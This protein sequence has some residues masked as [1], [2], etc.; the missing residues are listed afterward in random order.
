[1]G[2]FTLWIDTEKVEL[3]VV[4]LYQAQCVY[5]KHGAGV[6]IFALAWMGFPLSW[7]QTSLLLT[8]L[9]FHCVIITSKLNRSQLSGICLLGQ[10][11]KVIDWLARHCF[12]LGLPSTASGAC[13]VV[14][15]SPLKRKCSKWQASLK[16][17]LHMV[18]N[19]LICLTILWWS[20]CCY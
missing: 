10:S 9:L 13:T 15:I 12:P 7:L 2:L 11:C 18:K 19:N 16:A 3:N 17:A 20:M 5:D 4:L 6:H 14:E 8:A 1:M